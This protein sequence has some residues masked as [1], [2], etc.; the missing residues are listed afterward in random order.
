M[1]SLFQFTSEIYVLL[2]WKIYYV[3]GLSANVR[4]TTHFIRDKSHHPQFLGQNIK[5][6]LQYFRDK[7]V[8]FISTENHIN[9]RTVSLYT[10][11]PGLV[12]KIS[13]TFYF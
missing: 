1:K 13:S 7:V 11:R 10:L 9:F 2:W 3:H 8:N 4:E 6:S 12:D 5:L